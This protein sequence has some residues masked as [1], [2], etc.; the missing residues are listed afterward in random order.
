MRIIINRLLLLRAR[1]ILTPEKE[2][3]WNSRFWIWGN[4]KS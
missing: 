3:C 4:R 1:L 2:I